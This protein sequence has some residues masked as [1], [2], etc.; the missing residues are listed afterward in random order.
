MPVRQI[1][2]ISDYTVIEAVG[3]TLASLLMTEME[4]P[5]MITVSSPGEDYGV[6]VG[7]E[8]EEL[9]PSRV[10][11]FLYHVKE[12]SH[13]INMDWVDT[14][15]GS[16]IPYPL[17][18]QLYYM[19]NIFTP[20]KSSNLD[21]HRIL[22]DVMRVFHANPIIDSI[23]FEGTLNP[24]EEPMGIPWEELKIIHHP[25]PLDELAAIWHAINKPYRLSV[26]YE[27]SVSMIHPPSHRSRR[28]RRVDVT[29]VKA[30]P[31]RGAP[32]VDRIDPES[33]YGG[34]PITIHGQGFD[35]PFLKV[36]FNG[37]RV[38]PDSIASTRIVLTLPTGTPPG[39]YWIEVR[40]EEGSSGK[41]RFEEISPF[42]YRLSPEK[43]FT[44]DP[45]YPVNADG[46][47][48]LHI[49]GGNFT[50]DPPVSLELLL[51]PE[52]GGSSIQLI[53]AEDYTRNRIQWLIPAAMREGRTRITVRQDG[54][55]L[56]NALTLTIPSPEIFRVDPEPISTLPQEM[57]IMGD[58]FRTVPASTQ[59]YMHA[60]PLN[61]Y[62]DL[63]PAELLSIS[64]VSENEIRTTLPGTVGDGT[65][66]LVVC[67][68]G[69][70]YSLPF[71]IN[72]T[73]AE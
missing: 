19:L 37:V 5:V 62:G 29:H 66:L 25:L 27:T 23:F 14:G 52:S 9:G 73:T 33:G 35:S 44:E 21:E 65:Y 54:T 71:E 26:A 59:L 22:G 30:R 4:N 31:F 64:V 10:N 16:Q 48:L 38:K 13:S 17:S 55:R 57:I 41:I 45:D 32:G 56:S 47:P 67:V 61:D 24:N 46:D 12:A 50:T 34:Q 36:L 53:P 18:L 63:T 60:G 6:A 3:R 43:K 2:T 11:L 70:Y 28:I 72:V 69:S 1:G 20:D 42:L 49:W 51:G 39:L 58:Y 68:Y 7:S 8:G 15:D 40:N